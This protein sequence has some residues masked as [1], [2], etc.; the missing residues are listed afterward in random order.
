M[1]E[2]YSGVFEGASAGAD[3]QRLKTILEA[4]EFY[5]F[6]VSIG[7]TP[8]SGRTVFVE[9]EETPFRSRADAL[10]RVID[11]MMDPLNVSRDTFNE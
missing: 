4:D 7:F 1:Q 2:I 10:C 6:S 8:S 9:V 11:L 3:L 5:H